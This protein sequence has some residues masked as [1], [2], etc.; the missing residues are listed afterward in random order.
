MLISRKM[1]ITYSKRN[2]SMMEFSAIDEQGEM[3]CADEVGRRATVRSIERNLDRYDWNL[4]SSH[5]SQSNVSCSS[6]CY[7]WRS[8]RRSSFMKSPRTNKSM[9]I[10]DPKGDSRVKEAETAG[11]KSV[12]ALVMNGAAFHINFGAGIDALK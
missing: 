3:G 10:P 6:G 1:E 7:F 5:K 11:V 2:T 4:A 12:P 9:L 8:H